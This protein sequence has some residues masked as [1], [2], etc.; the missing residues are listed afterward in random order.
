MAERSLTKDLK[1]A[2]KEQKLKDI[3][4]LPREGVVIV[5][6]NLEYFGG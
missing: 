5:K 4:K 1:E 6:E 2:D 3:D